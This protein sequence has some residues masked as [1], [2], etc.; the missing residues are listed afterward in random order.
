MTFFWLSM[1]FFWLSL[2]FLALSLPV[3]HFISHMYVYMLT[4]TGRTVLYIGVTNNLLRRLYEHHFHNG[5][6]SKFTGRYQADLLVYFELCSDTL[7]AIA[8]EKQLKGWTRAKKE[9]LINAL[10]PNWEDIDIE[11]WQG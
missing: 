5:D 1:T 8:R 11:T 2:P 3:P 4:N 6:V 7:Q 9:A 10:N